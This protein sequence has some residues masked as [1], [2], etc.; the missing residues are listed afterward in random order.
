MGCWLLADVASE[1]NPGQRGANIRPRT[2]VQTRT[3]ASAMAVIRRHRVASPS[4]M[5]NA[6][7]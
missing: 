4:P 3:L 5:R 7:S 1:V 6:A 2:T